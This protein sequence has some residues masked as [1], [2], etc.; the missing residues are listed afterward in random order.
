MRVN[1]VLPMVW[2]TALCRTLHTFSNKCYYKACQ[3]NEICAVYPTYLYKFYHYVNIITE[4][5]T[6]E[7]FV[8]FSF[9]SFFLFL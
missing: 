2:P 4:C 9:L 1:F 3:V 5:K 8:L 6:A 7:F